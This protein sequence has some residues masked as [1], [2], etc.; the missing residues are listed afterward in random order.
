MDE[1]LGD[2]FPELKDKYKVIKSIGSGTYT[3][4]FATIWVLTT[5]TVVW[6]AFLQEATLRCIKRLP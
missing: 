3:L 1:S 2:L 6:R 4:V 5:L